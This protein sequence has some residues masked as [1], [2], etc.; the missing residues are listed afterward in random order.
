MH[1]KEHGDKKAALMLFLH[2]GGVS[3]WM[4]DKQIQS[5][6]H[7]HCIVPD[8][9]EQG[10]SNDGTNFSIKTSAE[11]L[12]ELVQEKAN[13]KQVIVIGFSLGAQVTIQMLSMKPEL[14]DYAMI[15]SALVRP[16]L[17]A[18]KWISPSIKLTFPL[19]RNQSFS[20]IQARALYI[21]K[22]NFENYYKETRQMKSDTLIRILE[23]NMSFEIPDHFHKATGRILV[24]VGEKEKGIMKKSAIDIV[25][26]NPN[27]IGMMIPNIGHGL[28]IA[29]PAFFNQIIEEWIAEG[30]IPEEG[31]LINRSH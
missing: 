15:N 23:E 14:I 16:M 3:G 9:A 29:N 28:P 8:L 6:M 7:Y 22:D 26:G 18:K 30:R 10:M 11:K 13:G 19:I 31:K 20:R 5:F 25:N 24:T 12:I 17:W 1:Y 2:G 27:S 4:W 21:G